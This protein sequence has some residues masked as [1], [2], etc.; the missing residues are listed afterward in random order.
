MLLLSWHASGARKREAALGIRRLKLARGRPFFGILS[1]TSGAFRALGTVGVS[2]PVARLGCCRATP[3][4]SYTLTRSRA[5]KQG[6]FGNSRGLL[7]G[8]NT[9]FPCL[10][11]NWH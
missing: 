11:E 4:G 6:H 3:D 1:R 10:N 7:P 5:E 2:C 9:D 8:P